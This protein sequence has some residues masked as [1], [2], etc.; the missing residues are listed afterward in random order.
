MDTVSRVRELVASEVEAAGATIYDLELAGGV[1]RLT[2]DRPG[3][4]DLEVIASVTRSVSRLLDEA[5]P[6]AGEY[7]LEV[8]SP[9]LERPLR[10]PEHFER[11]VGDTVSVKTRPGVEGDRRLQGELVAAD[12]DGFVVRDAASGGERRL[13]YRDVER[14]RTVFE[15]GPAP[16]PG[17]PRAGSRPKSSQPP[18]KKARS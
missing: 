11:A 8:T 18:Q 5:D 12:A 9:G 16:K 7:T 6:I 13:A 4:V 10:T 14:A 3:G 1:L 2:L 17:G 15:W